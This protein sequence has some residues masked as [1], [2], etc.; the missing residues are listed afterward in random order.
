MGKWTKRIERLEGVGTPPL[1][2]ISPAP[3][4]PS[5]G[6]PVIVGGPGPSGDSTT[7]VFKTVEEARAYKERMRAE[8]EARRRKASETNS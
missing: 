4:E 6:S 7:P 8:K 2:D 3:T 1:P 5:G